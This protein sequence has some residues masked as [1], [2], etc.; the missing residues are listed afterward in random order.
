MCSIRTDLCVENNFQI[1]ENEIVFPVQFIFIVFDISLL[2]IY[3]RYLIK[4]YY[5]FQC[6]HLRRGNVYN[7]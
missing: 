5:T 6:F 1:E 2:C 3:F 7:T 4:S